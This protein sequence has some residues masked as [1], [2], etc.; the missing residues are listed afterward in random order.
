MRG[1]EDLIA[2]LNDTH[3]VVVHFQNVGDDVSPLLVIFGHQKSQKDA[4]VAYRPIANPSKIGNS[5]K[6]WGRGACFFPLA[7]PM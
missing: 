5:S 4:A 2:T 7:K 6:S 3:K 1:L